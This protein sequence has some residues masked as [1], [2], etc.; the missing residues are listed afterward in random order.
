MPQFNSAQLNSSNFQHHQPK[1]GPAHI[2]HI[3]ILFQK[4]R[5]PIV[6]INPIKYRLTTSNFFFFFPP[7]K[8][9]SYVKVRLMSCTGNSIYFLRVNARQ[10]YFNTSIQEIPSLLCINVRIPFRLKIQP[11]YIKKIYFHI[12][13]IRDIQRS[14]KLEQTKIVPKQEPNVLYRSRSRIFTGLFTA[15]VKPWKD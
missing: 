10:A 12:D 15:L 14:Y 4:L 11:K 2:I 1:P 6:N 9:T 8:Y 13:Y 7:E 5:Q 3:I